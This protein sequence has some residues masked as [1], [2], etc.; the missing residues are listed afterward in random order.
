[1]T[2]CEHKEWMGLPVGY[3][4]FTKWRCTDCGVEMSAGEFII[5]GEVMRMKAR[6]C[7]DR[8]YEQMRDDI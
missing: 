7:P 8:S 4:P 2:E 3:L 6:L 1:M 5:Y